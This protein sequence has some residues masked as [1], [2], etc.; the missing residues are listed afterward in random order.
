MCKEGTAEHCKVLLKIG[1]NPNAEAD[2]DANGLKPEY[3]TTPLH[4]ANTQDVVR[5]LLQFGADANA[6]DGCDSDQRHSVL[7]N[8]LERN[9]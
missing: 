8:Y 6:A 9:P 1:A 4:L 7:D 2:P 5:T 3:S